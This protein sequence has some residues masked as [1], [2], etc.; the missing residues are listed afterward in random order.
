VTLD[1]DALGLAAIC[2]AALVGAL[3][4][5]ALG[6]GFGLVTM[7]VLVLVL[8]PLP[9]VVAVN[10]LGALTSAVVIP[11]VRRLIPWRRLSLLLLPALAGVLPGV[12]LARAADEALLEI[13]VGVLILA[14]VGGT[15]WLR[16]ADKP[17]EGDVP[18]VVTGAIA[19]L[20]N[21]SV[22]VG[23]PALGIYG[24]LGDWPQRTYAAAL[25]PFFLVLS[26]VTVASKTAL[27]P[28]DLPPWSWW[29]WGL[30]ALPLIGGVLIGHRVAARLPE[31]TARGVILLISVLGGVSVLWSG[32]AG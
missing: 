4:Q 24:A 28:A 1:A 7:P 12:L 13:V 14:G 15:L 30:V 27:S 21:A 26:I 11:Q 2:V 31:R 25:Q 29:T 5:R 18:V 16:R 23:A 9:A 10:V 22:G 3:G 20:L 17:L 19:G 32:I 6:M 8:G